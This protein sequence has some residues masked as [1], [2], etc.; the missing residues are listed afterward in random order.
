MVLARVQI[1]VAKKKVNKHTLL[2]LDV[3]QQIQANN[4]NAYLAVDIFKLHVT[5]TIGLQFFQ[6][7]IAKHIGFKHMIVGIV[8]HQWF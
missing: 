1:N 5:K 6:H 2:E 8:V 4:C 3:L 7:N